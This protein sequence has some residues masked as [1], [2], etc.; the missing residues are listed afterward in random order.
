MLSRRKWT[1]DGRGFA[2]ALEGL[3]ANRADVLASRVGRQRNRRAKTAVAHDAV[4]ADAAIRGDPVAADADG[5]GERRRAHLT[6]AFDVDKAPR[7]GNRAESWRRVGDDL[8]LAR[9]LLGRRPRT[10]TDGR[11]SPPRATRPSARTRRV[12]ARSAPSS[13]RDRAP[14]CCRCSPTSSG[15]RASRVPR[16]GSTS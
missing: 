12:P 16:Y 3:H 14:C 5:K 13:C 2:L 8:A 11:P 6:A 1:S 15:C 7:I 4:F 10:A 9:Q